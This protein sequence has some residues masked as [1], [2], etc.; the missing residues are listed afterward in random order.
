MRALYEEKNSPRL[1]AHRSET[2]ASMMACIGNE[3][4]KLGGLPGGVQHRNGLL[5]ILMLVKCSSLFRT[6]GVRATP[7]LF[8]N[9]AICALVTKASGQ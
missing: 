8:M 3:G 4:V 9:R 6:I 5:I 2:R 1:L 7:S